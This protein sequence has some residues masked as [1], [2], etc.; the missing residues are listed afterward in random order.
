[1]QVHSIRSLRSAVAI[2]SWKK[3]AGEAR[4]DGVPHRPTRRS[5]C[6][7]RLRKRILTVDPGDNFAYTQVGNT[8][9]GR[10][11]RAAC[12][13]KEIVPS[14]FHEASFTSVLRRCTSPAS[15]QVRPLRTK[16][17]TSRGPSL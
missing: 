13:Q 4:L 9:S 7:P 5:I 15:T 2:R 6:T 17:R 10:V 11:S 14:P 8:L 12:A 3:G 16:V 1:V